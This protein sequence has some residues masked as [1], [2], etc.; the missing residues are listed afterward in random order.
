ME[1]KD[2]YNRSFKKLRISLT[3]LCNLACV[4]CTDSVSQI[5]FKK[6]K[7]HAKIKEYLK[8]VTQ[9][10]ELC[11][12]EAI[13]LT[14]GE[15]LLFNGIEY[16]IYELSQMGIPKI[17]LT[18]NAVFLED[19]AEVLKDAGLNSINISLDAIEEDA[20]YQIT[21]RR[22]LDKVLRGIDKA[23]ELHFGMKINAVIMKGLNDNQVLPLFKYFKQK[24]I[25]IRYLEFMQMGY[26]HSE[27]EQN[28]FSQQQILDRLAGITDFYALERDPSSTS[29]YWITSDLYKFGIIANTTA[30]FCKDCD[31]LR[32][33]NDMKIYGCLSNP[34]GFSVSEVKEK[35]E[36]KT[37]LE[38]A[39][40]QKQSLAFKG[41]EL[42]MKY[43]GG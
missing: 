27:F 1:I 8:N 4:Y 9:L 18:T 21:K 36:L 7:S 24:E 17:A 41:S 22:N 33:G 40:D 29:N 20:F 26:L 25:T 14:G 42:S 32:L 3:D 23:Q 31:R 16:L 43:I 12:F 35:Q 5:D 6:I 19:K 13:R 2:R 15:P 34:N 28:F 30:P 11:G 10:H 37:I 39:L 38:K